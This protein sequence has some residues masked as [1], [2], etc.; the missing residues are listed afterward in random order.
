[1]NIL[2]TGASR[3]IG[4]S[5]AMYYKKKGHNLYLIARDGEKLKKLSENYFAVD[6]ADFDEVRNISKKLKEVKFDLII[7]NAGVS[8]LHSKDF[9]PFNA[10]EKVI[11]VNFLSIHALLENINFKNSKIVFISSL[12][13]LVGAP[14]SLP[15]SASKRAI[16]SYAESLYFAGV[17]VRLILPGFIKTDM[18]KKHTFHMPF[19]M[20][21]DKAGIKIVKIIESKKFFNP[22]PL[23]FYYIIKFFMLLP[24]GLKRKILKK[25]VKSDIAE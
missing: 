4:K 1:M 25:Y 24:Y 2:I 11:D 20:D 17:D 9:P 10:F 16:N 15:Y 5:L 13:S 6:L 18:T 21:L 8:S 23:R 3:G 7:L 19:L 22:F 12:A 14:T